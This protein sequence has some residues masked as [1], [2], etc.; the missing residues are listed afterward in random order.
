M[1]AFIAV[2]EKNNNTDRLK[3]TDESFDQLSRLR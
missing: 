3:G 1:S 2:F